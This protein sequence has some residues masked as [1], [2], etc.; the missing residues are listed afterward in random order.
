MKEDKQLISD[1]IQSNQKAVA[2]CNKKL[3][4]QLQ[5]LKAIVSIF[6]SLKQSCYKLDLGMFIIDCSHL[7]LKTYR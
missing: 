2:D 3:E 7:T 4:Q 5:S 1:L 6:E